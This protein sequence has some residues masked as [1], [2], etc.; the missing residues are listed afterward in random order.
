[1][2]LSK[3][4]ALLGDEHVA[5]CSDVSV[6]ATDTQLVV[7]CIMRAPSWRTGKLCE[8]WFSITH[9]AALSTRPL[10]QWRARA[11]APYQEHRTRMV[12][13]QDAKEL[14]VLL[15]IVRQALKQTTDADLRVN[16]VPVTLAQ[17]DERLCAI[18]AL[19]R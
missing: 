6:I 10:C 9:D 13:P 16:G 4:L 5:S 17:I 7:N 11:A 12:A 3:T 15:R 18:E 2:S 14:G 1:M 8:R 19:A